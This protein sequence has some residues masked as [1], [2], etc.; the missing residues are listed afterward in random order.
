MWIFLNDSFL[1]IVRHHDQPDML[2]VRARVPGDIEAVFPEA[3]IL[4]GVG[5]DYRYRSVLSQD[6]VADAL[7]S[8]LKASQ[9]TNFKASV[10]DQVR[11]DAYMRVWETM[12]QWGEHTRSRD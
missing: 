3:E 2:L 8:R 7:T 6:V 9:Y 1:S 11:H 5:T 12:R 10:R 4:E